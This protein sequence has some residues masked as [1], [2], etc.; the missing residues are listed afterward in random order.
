MVVSIIFPFNS[1][2]KPLNRPDVLKM[3]VDYFKLKKVVAQI[4]A[5]LMNTES[6]L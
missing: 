1:L 5:Y 2:V 6:L 3:T 4:A